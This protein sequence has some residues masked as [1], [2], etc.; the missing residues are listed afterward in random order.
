MLA[1]EH[2]IY[3]RDG[4]VGNEKRKV[5]KVKRNR[6]KKRVSKSPEIKENEDSRN[7]V[8]KQSKTLGLRS[9]RLSPVA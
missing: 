4:L 5:L 2:W 9:R 1:D 7:R 8:Q 6:L 3:L